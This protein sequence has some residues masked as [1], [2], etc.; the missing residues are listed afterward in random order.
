MKNET[1]NR[2]AIFLALMLL[3]ALAY[4]ILAPKFGF[5]ADD[6]YSIYGVSTRGSEAFWQIFSFDRPARAI[7]MIPLYNL[8][9]ASAP[10]YSYSGYAVRL[11]GAFFFYWMLAGLWPRRQWVGALAALLYL[12]YPG[13]LEQPNA[14]D[15]QSHLWSISAGLISIAFSVRAQDPGLKG[16]QRAALLLLSMPLTVFYLSQMEYFIGLEG[17]R[18]FLIGYCHLRSGP[19]KRRESW[20]RFVVGWLPAVLPS[21]VFLGWRVFFF[22]GQR[23]ETDL[24]LIFAQLG[25]SALEPAWLGIHWLQDVFN[26]L[27]SAWVIPLYQLTMGMRL[28]EI[29]LIGSV[30]LL[31]AGAAALFV[32]SQLRAAQDDAT[33]AHQSGAMIWIGLAAVLVALIPAELGGRRIEFLN[34]TRYTLPV[35]VGVAMLVAGWIG[36][37][38]GR[39]RMIIAAALIC[40]MAVSTHAAN[41]SQSANEAQAVRDFWWQMTWR[42]PQLKLGTTLLTQIPEVP[43]LVDY[44]VWGPANLIYYPQVMQDA[45]VS[46]PVGAIIATPDTIQNFEMKSV[47][48]SNERGFLTPQNY[49]QVLVVWMTDGGCLKAIDGQAPELSDAVNETAYMAA[50][51]SHLDRIDTQSPQSIPPTSIFGPEPR[52]T[53]CYYFEKASLA[54]QRGDWAEVARLGDEARSFNFTSVDWVE[55]MPFIQAYANQGEFSKADDFSWVILEKPW[56]RHQACTDF[57]R[58]PIPFAAGQKYLVDKFCQ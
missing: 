33:E 18:A 57:S 44:A 49:Q 25:S 50:P 8:F 38:R 32:A 35:S 29:L 52:H 13:F 54:R 27:L 34:Q 47:L 55:N 31:A 39:G 20:K 23:S 17:L 10:L 42:A 16:W 19:I 26:A 24:G 56:L 1:F 21:L 5:H 45:G 36:D 4:L 43:N 40:G 14:F 37:L 15:Y 6:W 2:V 28:R 51:Y 41:A 46:L 48:S 11:V 12:I 53:W 7:L 9:G 22:H 30:G 3:S 58:V